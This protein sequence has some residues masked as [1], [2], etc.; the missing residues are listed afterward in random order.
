MS[1]LREKLLKACDEYAHDCEMWPLLSAV[2]DVVEAA[3]PF[4]HDPTNY[5]ELGQRIIIKG[6]ITECNEVMRLTEAIAKLEQILTDAR[7]R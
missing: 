5:D 1:S 7:E 4:A 3:K 6:V 2:A